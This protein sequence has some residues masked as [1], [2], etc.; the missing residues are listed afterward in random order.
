M[1]GANNMQTPAQVAPQDLSREDLVAEYTSLRSALHSCDWQ[2]REIT[3]GIAALAS[4]ARHRLA[5]DVNA[6]GDVAVLLAL[7]ADRAQYLADSVEGMADGCGCSAFDD[8]T[9][10]GNP[11]AVRSELQRQLSAQQAHAAGGGQ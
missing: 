7:M 8:H 10:P 11:A 4:A 6:L 9:R 2:V 5:L 3:E 1:S